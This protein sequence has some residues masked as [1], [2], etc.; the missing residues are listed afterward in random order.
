[1]SW[2]RP[3]QRGFLPQRSILSNITEIDE[4]AQ[5]ADLTEDSAGLFLF[6]FEAAFP[7]I[8]QTFMFRMLE[9]IGVPAGAL[10]LVRALYH[11]NQCT[12]KVGRTI[13]GGLWHFCR[14]SPRL[15]T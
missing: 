11:E 10:T 6:D 12:L 14:D 8:S 2:I 7:S 1:M 5:R 15:P 3:E 13:W 4:A 9:Y